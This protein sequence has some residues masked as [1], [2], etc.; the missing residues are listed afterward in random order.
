MQPVARAAH[1]RYLAVARRLRCTKVEWRRRSSA[2]GSLT[3]ESSVF[4]IVLKNYRCFEDTDPLTITID[5]GFT[6]LVGPNNSG[7]SSVLRFFFEFREFWNEVRHVGHFT[8][9]V[10]TRRS[11]SIAGAGEHLEIFCDRNE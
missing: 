2:R 11:V 4:E 8:N 7:K 5:R 1:R 9:W 10:R 6:A 3:I